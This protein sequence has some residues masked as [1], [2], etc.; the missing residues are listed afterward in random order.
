MRQA[1]MMITALS[2]TAQIPNLT[3]NP[4]SMSASNYWIFFLDLPH[5]GHIVKFFR[6]VREVSGH[7]QDTRQSASDAC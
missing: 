2:R 4:I 1:A 5:T 7:P 3:E 6:L